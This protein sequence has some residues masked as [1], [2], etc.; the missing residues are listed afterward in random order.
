MAEEKIVHGLED[1][2]RPFAQSDAKCGMDDIATPI[3]G[4]IATIGEGQT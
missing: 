3:A 1:E 2:Q 4:T